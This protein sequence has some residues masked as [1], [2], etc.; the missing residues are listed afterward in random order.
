MGTGI[1]VVLLL[2]FSFALGK[3]VETNQALNVII[4]YKQIV[5]YN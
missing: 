2:P 5:F 1:R 3:G 4:G